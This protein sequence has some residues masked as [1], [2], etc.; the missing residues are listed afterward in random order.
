MA[1]AGAD[2]LMLEMMVDT[3][4][5]LVALDAAQASGLPVWVGLSCTVD[6]SG[7][8]RLVR[9]G[10]L[11]DALQ[12][13][14]DQNVPLINIMHTHVGNIAACLDVVAAHWPGAVGVYADSSKPVGNTYAYNETVSPQDYAAHATLWIERGVQAIGACCGLG[15]EHI[16]AL[17]PL[18]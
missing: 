10:L 18:F 11:A 16:R 12:A 17:K 1:D 6:P 13:L 8:V 2:L 5:M 14:R 7:A 9:G 3:E 4:R 15:V